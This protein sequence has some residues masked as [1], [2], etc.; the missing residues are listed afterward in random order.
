[1]AMRKMHE[2][3]L[4]PIGVKGDVNLFQNKYRREII[5]TSEPQFFVISYV[6]VSKGA[7]VR[8]ELR[9]GGNVRNP[10]ANTK[11]IS[12]RYDS[13]ENPEYPIG[14]RADFT[15]IPI[16]GGTEVSF[17]A[18]TKE[19]VEKETKVYLEWLWFDGTDGVIARVLFEKKGKVP[20]CTDID[21]YKQKI[22]KSC[23]DADDY[24]RELSKL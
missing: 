17:W 2:V 1:M 10:G 24:E 21:D 16:L 19:P 15:P 23:I 6:A 20:S 3:F 8:L 14:E 11:A 12:G 9:T 22:S 4:L 5:K 7:P 13:D 18:Q